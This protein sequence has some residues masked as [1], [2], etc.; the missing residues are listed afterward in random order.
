ML[1]PTSRISSSTMTMTM[2][3]DATVLERQHEVYGLQDHAPVLRDK[4]TLR[5]EQVE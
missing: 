2:T 5:R 4:S 3:L 1:P